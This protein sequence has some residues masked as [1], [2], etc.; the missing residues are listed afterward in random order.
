MTFFNRI[1]SFVCFALLVLNFAL[2][3]PDSEAVTW[4]KHRDKFTLKKSKKNYDLV[5][6]ALFRNESLFLK[7]WIE[8]HKLVGVQ[9]FYLYNN[10]SDDNY[11]EILQPYLLSGEVELFDVPLETNTQQENLRKLQIPIYEHALAIVRETARWAAFIDLDEFLF[12]V[13]KNQL[14]SLLKE[15]EE[16]PG[17]VVNWQ[18][19]GTG[20]VDSLPPKGLVIESLLMKVATNGECNHMVKSIVQPKFVERITDAHSFVYI[21]GLCA[22]NSNRE[23]IIPGIG[24]HDSIVV[25]QVRLNH[26]WFGTRDWFYA[27]KVPRRAKWGLNTSPIY[28]E[29]VIAGANQ[30]R[31]EEILR[32]VP[33]LRE[34]MYPSP[35]K[36]NKKKGRRHPEAIRQLEEIVDSSLVA[37]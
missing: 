24:R 9:H 36:G 13:Q 34:K 32:F 20:W 14:V 28:L 26:Y 16:F 19:Y 5:I 6:C 31:D 25:D 22:V 11:L 37:A 29:G 8:F 15:Y 35:K 21:N 1:Q 18:N 10:L 30:V 7:E 27:N 2:F 12:P 17:L 4:K 3:I 23:P 33:Q